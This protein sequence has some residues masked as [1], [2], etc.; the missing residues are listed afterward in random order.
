MKHRNSISNGHFRKHWQK[1][2]KTDFDK[3]SNKKRRRTIRVSKLT[4]T[5][6]YNFSPKNLLKPIVHNPT[7]MYNLKIR[8]G[9]GFSLSELNKSGISKKLACSIGVSIDKRRRGDS[10]RECTNTI[11]LNSYLR[12]L[13]LVSLKKS[14]T[15]NSIF[16]KIPPYKFS[17]R[18]FKNKFCEKSKLLIQSEQN[19]KPKLKAFQTLRPLSVRG[20]LKD[21]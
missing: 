16:E 21:F 5:R 2:V 15:E 20:K 8:L 1:F 10:L 18:Q 7:R 14:Q 11:R 17:E 4:K 9:R 19:I 13:N 6:R 3:S 12:K